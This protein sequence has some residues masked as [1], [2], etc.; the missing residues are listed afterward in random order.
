ML[1]KGKCNLLGVLVDAVDYE[2]VVARI[3]QAARRREALGVSA[4]AV[5]GLITGVS[6][7]GHRYRLNHLEIVTPDGQPVRW[8]LNA[9]HGAG[10]TDRVYGPQLTL[11]VLAAAAQNEVPVYLYG[12]SGEVVELF[13]SKME[14][15]FPGLVVAGAEPSR[16]RLLTRNE[17]SELAAR[18]VGS[19]ARVVFVGLGCPRQE[20]FVYQ[21]RESLS[22]PVLAVGAAFD[23]HAGTLVEPPLWL[24]RIGFQWLYRLCQE[25]RRLA[26]RY[27]VTNARFSLLAVAQLFHLWTPHSDRCVPPDEILYG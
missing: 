16:F 22:M 14:A 10:L 17:Q 11:R 2:Y 12:S 15:R 9:L 7:D 27:V 19:G 13:R 8:L 25:P 18:I 20:V 3:L 1:N 23:Y 26:K 24:Q 21:N 5:H 6:D 4:L